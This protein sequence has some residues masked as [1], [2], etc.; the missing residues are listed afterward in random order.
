[1]WCKSDDAMQ[2]VEGGD[3]AVQVAEVIAR[4]GMRGSHVGIGV[5]AMQVEEV[6]S[7][8]VMRG[9]QGDL[10]VRFRLALW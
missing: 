3:A 1:M 10:A 5:D 2:G 4:A 7:Q 6:A 9:L 8:T